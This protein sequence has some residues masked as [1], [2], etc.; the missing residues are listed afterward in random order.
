MTTFLQIDTQFPFSLWEPFHGSIRVVDACRVHNVYTITM[1]A[2]GQTGMDLEVQIKV[3]TPTS[4]PHNEHE[5]MITI[6]TL[7][8][9]LVPAPAEEGYSWILEWKNRVQENVLWLFDIGNHST[10]PTL[11]FADIVGSVLDITE[12]VVKR[13]NENHYDTNTDI[14]EVVKVHFR[15]QPGYSTGESFSLNRIESL[16]RERGVVLEL[17]RECHL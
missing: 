10:T 4:H 3:G 17:S 2:V 8:D 16:C 12:E 1:S 5:N 14:L 9:R 11:K 15:Q 7:N 13:R 6:A